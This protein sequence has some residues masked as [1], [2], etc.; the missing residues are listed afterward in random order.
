[1]FQYGVSHTKIPLCILKING[2]HFVRHSGRAYFP[3]LY[4]LF[5]I[6]H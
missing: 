3:V 2:I 5:E 4:L 1:M 6:V